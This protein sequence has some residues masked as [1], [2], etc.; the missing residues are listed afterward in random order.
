MD[1]TINRNFLCQKPLLTTFLKLLFL[2]FAALR[3]YYV[4]FNTSKTIFV[5]E[6][7]HSC[8]CFSLL[9]QPT[10]YILYFTT[11][12]MSCPDNRQNKT[13]LT[14]FSA[15][16]VI[17]IWLQIHVKIFRDRKATCGLCFYRLYTL[18]QYLLV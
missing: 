8:S 1:T 9:T 13:I 18:T 4:L 11:C 6:N 5:K 2:P 16:Y 12:K 14:L 15:L 17:Y 10:A 3:T 7:S